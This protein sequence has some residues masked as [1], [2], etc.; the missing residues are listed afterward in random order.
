MTKG[1]QF[2]PAGDREG[3]WVSNK[4]SCFEFESGIEF[5]VGLFSCSRFQFW[6][7]FHALHLSVD[8]C[9]DD[10]FIGDDKSVFDATLLSKKITSTDPGGKKSSKNCISFLLQLCVPVTNL[11]IITDTQTR[12]D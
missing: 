1:R 5:N 12:E 6:K 4:C 2:V 9:C 10:Y 7:R 11:I 3:I 8:F